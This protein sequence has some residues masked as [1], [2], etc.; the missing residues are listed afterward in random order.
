MTPVEPV[1][2]M[3]GKKCT[4]H[5]NLPEYRVTGA[6]WLDEEE[7]SERSD[8]KWPFLLSSFR[9]SSPS[10]P[11]FAARLWWKLGR[12]EK[13]RKQRSVSLLWFSPSSTPLPAS[14]A[15]IPWKTFRATHDNREWTFCKTQQWFRLNLWASLLYN[16]KAKDTKHDE[17]GSVK[18]HLSG[19]C[20]TSGCWRASLKYA[21][22]VISLKMWCT[23]F[24]KDN[25]DYKRYFLF[26][27][28]S[29]VQLNIFSDII[30][31]WRVTLDRGV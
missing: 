16:S 21:F 23:C 31:M 25:K 28:L 12:E 18:M 30:H 10:S 15:P 27:W 4:L 3:T 6:S 26:R 7:R 29:Y 14:P 19:K 5:F 1:E 24:Y 22:P 17:F 11:P 13:G 2:D 20:V 8:S 9:L